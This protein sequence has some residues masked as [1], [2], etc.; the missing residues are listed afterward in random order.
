[1]RIVTRIAVLAVLA[2]ACRD[3]KQA[4]P[5]PPPPPRQGLE[6]V[7]HGAMPHRPLR[8]QLTRG[9]KTVVE[10]EVDREI[11]TSREQHRMPTS[12]TVMEVGAEDVLPDGNAQVRT[13][14]LRASAR[15]RPGATTSVEVA[16]AQGAML[17]GVAITGTLTP[18]GKIFGPRLAAGPNL[19]AKTTQ[20]AGP[21]IEQTEDVAMPLPEPGVGVGAIWR[22]RR[23]LMQLGLKLESITELEVTAIDGPRVTYAMRTEVKG[24]D[25]RATIDGTQVDVTN[26]RGTGSGKGVIDLGRMVSFGEQTLELGFDISAAGEPGTVKMRTTKRL[27][28]ASE[29]PPPEP[30]P[31]QEP[32]KPPAAPPKQAPPKAGDQGA[33]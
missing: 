28:P 4:P 14:I 6:M 15:D 9:V 32:P 22:V 27:K 21:L 7:N 30:A 19:P 3:N 1:M 10:L 5:A 31:K 16:N 17:S 26:V 12:V 25:Q 29:A 33:H 13:T 20:E 24:D 8:Y 2:G 18:R 11:S 23:D